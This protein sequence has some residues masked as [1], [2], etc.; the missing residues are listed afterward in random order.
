MFLMYLDESGHEKD[1]ESHFILGGV[2]INEFHVEGLSEEIDKYAMRISDSL[3][4]K[5]DPNSIEFH[6]REIYPGE[7][8]PWK[9]MTIEQRKEVIKNVL[10]IF[11]ESHRSNFAYGCAVEKKFF[12][13]DN[14]LELAFEDLLSRF[15]IQLNQKKQKGLIIVDKSTHEIALQNLTKCFFQSGTRW[16]NINHI[17]DVP[18]FVDSKSSRIIQIADHIAY[19]VF[20]KYSYKDINY[21][22][23]ISHRF[24]R[25]GKKFLSLCHKTRDNKCT[26]ESCI[27]R[28]R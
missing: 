14:P 24:S 28:I 23:I 4:N 18:F 9:S 10:R 27:S 16:G 2:S 11:E 15:D 6:A 25:H 26:C 17:V 21:F 19:S 13:E 5:I 7:I 20:R 8:E 1:E 3:T 22:D 12:L